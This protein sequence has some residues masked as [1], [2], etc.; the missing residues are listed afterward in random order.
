MLHLNL[1]EDNAGQLAATCAQPAMQLDHLKELH[2][3]CAAYSGLCKGL[4]AW[5]LS[6][7]PNIE[8]LSCCAFR[9]LFYFP[10]LTTLKHLMLNSTDF[11]SLDEVLRQLP[12]LE[13]LLLDGWREVYIH[14]DADAFPNAAH[15]SSLDVRS[16]TR[17]TH[18]AFHEVTVGCP[19]VPAA[20]KVSVSITDAGENFGSLIWANLG[21]A[22]RYFYWS[23]SG[24]IELE[25]M[26][27]LLFCPALTYVDMAADESFGN[28]DTPIVLAGHLANLKCLFI[29]AF[30]VHVVVPAD[31]EWKAFRVV[32]GRGGLHL[33]FEDVQ[34][35]AS[36]TATWVFSGPRLEESGVRH[37]LREAL[38]AAGKSWDEFSL[39][40][41]PVH[42]RGPGFM[43]PKDVGWKLPYCMCGAC[44]DC[45]MRR[46]VLSVRSCRSLQLDT[47]WEQPRWWQPY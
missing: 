28:K 47:A 15:L 38:S 17:L 9:K 35:F 33:T 6:K 2:F 22:L 31:V 39:D 40:N 12:A 21:T 26:H 29:R 23:C 45:L 24:S 7:T 4:L 41:G 16:N 20:C 19:R 43:C 13:T 10:P 11:S 42:L 37:A 36:T 1:N 8:A 14:E 27:G 34:R 25:D 3:R 44:R 18:I 5:L 32:A 46:G 30:E